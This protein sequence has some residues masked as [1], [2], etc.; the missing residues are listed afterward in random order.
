MFNRVRY[1]KVT[2]QLL[3]LPPEDFDNA[4]DEILNQL[5]VLINSSVPHEK[6]GGIA[7]IGKQCSFLPVTKLFT[8]LIDKLIDIIQTFNTQTSKTTNITNFLHTAFD[9]N[10]E[11]VV[12]AAAKAIG[13]RNTTN[14]PTTL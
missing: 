12:F 1:V 10:D 14:H 11:K 7:A 2:E 9:S 4:L 5:S 13:R 6:L 8:N 3:E